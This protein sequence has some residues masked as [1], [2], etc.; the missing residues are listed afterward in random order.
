MRAFPE[1]TIFPEHWK[2]DF[3]G[4]KIKLNYG[5]SQSAVQTPDGKFPIYGTGG[6]MGMASDWLSK[7]DSVLLGRKGTL[8][9]PLYIS[10]PFW[11]VDTTFYVSDFEGSYKWLYYLFKF[12]DLSRWNEAT[13]VPSLS[14]NNIEFIEIAFP[15]NKEQSKIA[16]VLATIDRAIA[17]TE[18]LIAKHQRIK[19]GLMQ[20]LLTRGI[21]EHGQLR[22]PSTHR[23]KSTPL[24]VMPEEWEVAPLKNK[25]TI[26]HGYSFLGE[27]FSDVDNGNLLLTPGNFHIE[28]GLYFDPE[29]TKYYTGKFPKEFILKNGDVLVVMTDLT[30]EMAILGNTVILDHP[31]N[32]LHNQRIGLIEQIS[33]EKINSKY[34]TL[35]M[36]S[37]FCK[38]VVKM[39]ATGTT[40]RHTSPTKILS[41]IL[42][43]A[44][45]DEQERVVAVIGNS[46]SQI[47]HLKDSVV[48]LGSLKQGLMQD[49][50]S[51]RVSVS[52]LME[53]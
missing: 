51:G 35:L 11:A 8:D 43:F 37:N 38:S 47:A 20:D 13:G 23:F 30:K 52:V 15:P 22:D 19:T 6:L 7:S 14:R 32:V 50:L 12:I 42:P 27:F 36:N 48:K 29:K 2:T 3:L 45:H 40:V 39:T 49:L 10:E 21:D 24:G 1:S 28:G 33:K 34:L 26:K 4:K 25:I 18:A 44:K 53:G 31:Q 9:N 46:E 17:Q 16:E 5:K 41:A